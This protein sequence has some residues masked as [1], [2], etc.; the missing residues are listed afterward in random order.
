MVSDKSIKG[1]GESHLFLL[2][3]AFNPPLLECFILFTR[4]F[5]TIFLKYGKRILRHA[6]LG[7]DFLQVVGVVTLARGVLQQVPF[8]ADDNDIQSTQKNKQN[9]PL[10]RNKQELNDL[11]QPAT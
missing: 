5:I 9:E 2:L 1:D 7:V 8:A 6:I 10:N 3:G 11:L 4:V